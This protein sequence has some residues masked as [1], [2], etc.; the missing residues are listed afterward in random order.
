MDKTIRQLFCSGTGI[1]PVNFNSGSR[2]PVL[3]A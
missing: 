3:L 2:T 1:L